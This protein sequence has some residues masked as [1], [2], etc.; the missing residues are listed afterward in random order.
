MDF[1]SY[2]KINKKDINKLEMI[3]QSYENLAMFSTMDSKIAVVRIMSDINNKEIITD[4]LNS[5]DIKLEELE[6]YESE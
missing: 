5:L 3:L 6:R 2:Y 1:I 4:I